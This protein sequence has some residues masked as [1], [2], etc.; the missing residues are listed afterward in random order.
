MIFNGF[1]DFVPNPCDLTQPRILKNSLREPYHSFEISPLNSVVLW[2]FPWNRFWSF[3]C[4]SFFA[5]PLAFACFFGRF[6]LLEC[7]VNVRHSIIPKIFLQTVKPL[8]RSGSGVVP[9]MLQT[10]FLSL[11]HQLFSCWHFVLTEQ[12]LLAGPS[13]SSYISID[14]GIRLWLLY[15]VLHSSGISFCFYIL[16]LGVHNSSSLG[17]LG[18][19]KYRLW[20]GL[21][22]FKKPTEH[23]F[24]PPQFLD[25]SCLSRS[26]RDPFSAFFQPFWLFLLCSA[27]ISPLW[28]PR[29]LPL[30]NMLCPFASLVRTVSGSFV[31]DLFAAVICNPFSILGRFDT[32]TFLFSM[33]YS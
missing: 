16:V 32:W 25:F 7:N 30:R 26:F 21:C 12:F 2:R 22:R 19:W 5:L 20:M 27:V 29:A 3:T 31:V 4:F 6:C 1:L 33:S 23:F 17:L 14:L 13:C 10:F 28:I 11:L 15:A 8:A 18:I 9:R 24:L